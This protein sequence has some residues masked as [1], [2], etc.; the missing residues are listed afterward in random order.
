MLF[1]IH[2]FRILGRDFCPAIRQVPFKQTQLNGFVVDS[3]LD[4][5]RMNR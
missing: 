3:L 1:S 4:Y 5:Q 2:N